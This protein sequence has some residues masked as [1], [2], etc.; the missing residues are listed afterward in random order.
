MNTPWPMAGVSNETSL[1]LH[2]VTTNRPSLARPSRK[3]SVRSRALGSRLAG[4]KRLPRRRC[5]SNQGNRRF[6]WRRDTRRILDGVHRHAARPKVVGHRVVKAP[7]TFPFRPPIADPAECRSAARRDRQS[8]C[9]PWIPEGL[10]WGGSCLVPIGSCVP[11][12]RRRGGAITFSGLKR[13]TSGSV[14]TVYTA[15]ASAR[16][17]R[18]LGILGS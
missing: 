17:K 4:M 11:W 7:G 1:A 3:S 16:A 9:R 13:P 12:R 5:S 10:V 18:R 15:S 14:S 6:D 8:R 2:A